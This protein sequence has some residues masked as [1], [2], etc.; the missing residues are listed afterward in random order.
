MRLLKF[1]LQNYRVLR[2]LTVQFSGDD[3]RSEDIRYALNLLVGVN[4]TG[5]STVLQALTEILYLLPVTDNIPYTFELEYLLREGSEPE[6]IRVVNRLENTGTPYAKRLRVWF[7]GEERDGFSTRFLPDK[8]IIFTTGNEE[9]WEQLFSTMKV[10]DTFEEKINTSQLPLLELTG[11]RTD[12]SKDMFDGEIAAEDNRFVFIRTIHLPL[13]ILCGMLSH[14]A[15]SSEIKHRLLHEVLEKVNIGGLRGF[16]LRF[17][18]SKEHMSPKELED[19][20]RLSGKAARSL[21]IGGELQLIFN[22]GEAEDLQAKD[23]LMEFKGGLMLFELLARLNSPLG[24]R[25]P[26]LREVNLFLDRSFTHKFMENPADNASPLHLHTWLSDG[27]QSFLARMCL[28]TLLG[29]NQALIMLDEPEV[30]FNDY[31]K[32]Q[33]V[34][35]IDHIIRDSRSHVLITTHSGITL[36]DVPSG[37]ILLLRRLYDHTSEALHPAIRT[38]AADPNEIITGVFEAPQATGERGIV[39]VKQEIINALARPESERRAALKRLDNMVGFGYWHYLVLRE[40][41]EMN[42]K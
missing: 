32:R 17:Y 36:T 9:N 31:W 30:H 42:P 18:I 38:L 5:K 22:M 11:R 8:I 20:R 24:S 14:M 35:L 23:L 6:R 16:S 4:G 10:L 41:R 27:E 29:N 39:R 3:T 12:S 37:D 7:N 1:Y 19:I 28:F 15:S 26:L 40:Q 2:D 25:P 34:N 13:L 21:D 33:I